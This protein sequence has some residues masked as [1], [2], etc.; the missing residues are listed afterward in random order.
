MS[1]EKKE[2]I[3]V[4]ATVAVSPEKAWELWTGPQHIM[5]WN[6]ASPDWHCPAA[7]NDVRVGGRFKFTMAAKDG[8]HSFD[9]SGTYTEVTAPSTLTYDMDGGRKASLIFAP[10]AEGTMI[11]ESFDPE[12][13]NPLEMQRA[14]WQAIMDSFKAYAEKP[15]E[16]SSV[17]V[18]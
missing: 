15:V 5:Q 1:E 14:G 7:E 17:P 6:Q 12:D 2:Q 10:V 3:T 8:S 9:F 11:T 18:E 4:S 13:T 16:V